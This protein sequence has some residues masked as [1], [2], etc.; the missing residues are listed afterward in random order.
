M[1]EK[2]DTRYS[3]DDYW[4]EVR[5]VAN[6]DGDYSMIAIYACSI[7]LQMKINLKT[8]TSDEII[9]NTDWKTFPL[10]QI[11]IFGVNRT[12]IEL[13]RNKTHFSPL[14][15]KPPENPNKYA[16][17]PNATTENPYEVLKLLM[18]SKFEPFIEI[19]DGI[20]NGNPQY[21]LRN[22]NYDQYRNKVKGYRHHPKDNRSTWNGLSGRNQ[23]FQQINEE[24][25]LR[26]DLN[27][28]LN[29]RK[30]L[31]VKEGQEY[32]PDGPVELFVIERNYTTNK[33]CN[34]LSKRW[35]YFLETPDRFATVQKKI[36][37]QYNG[38]D[39]LP[40]IIKKGRTKRSRKA[41]RTMG[42]HANVNMNN[43][44]AEGH[45]NFDIMKK[46]DN[47]NDPT[48]TIQNSRQITNRRYRENQKGNCLGNSTDQIATYFRELCEEG[49]AEYCRRLVKEKNGQTKPCLVCYMDW[50]LDAICEYCTT[51]NDNPQP[52]GKE[53]SS[54]WAIL[55]LLNFHLIGLY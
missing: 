50:Q 19:P 34:T 52:L 22:A 27:W 39:S 26:R 1:C 41:F 46:Y 37:L 42:A 24:M 25:K 33:D 7:S 55:I 47:P 49:S 14:V 16:D 8:E 53:K 32:I 23:V 17:Y 45:N 20:K 10:K 13:L 29:Q 28:S 51:A 18:D 40:A 12:E 5:K 44:V 36:F 4:D 54:I 38:V 11:D 6:G 31:Y 35:C 2:G 21:I 30:Y 9:C 48:N 43:A 15:S 3:Y